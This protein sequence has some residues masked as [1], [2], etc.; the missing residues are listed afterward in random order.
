MRKYTCGVPKEQCKGSFTDLNSGTRNLIVKTHVSPEEAFKC[1]K[2]WLLSQ[3]YTQV[4]NREFSPPNNGPIRVLSKKTHFGGVLRF[5][6]N[7]K[8]I[9]RRVMPKDFTG[10]MITVY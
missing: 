1:H 3:G 9:G 2:N 4:G 10:G 7:E 8:R 5:G 6:K